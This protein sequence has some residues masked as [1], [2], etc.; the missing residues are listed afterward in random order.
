MTRV[1][2]AVVAAALY[3]STA[4]AAGHIYR[5]ASS[6]YPGSGTFGAGGTATYVPADPTL[7]ISTPFT[8]WCFANGGDQDVWT[9][10]TFPADNTSNTFQPSIDFYGP[11]ASDGGNAV[12]GVTLAVCTAGANCTYVTGLAANS[13]PLL[14]ASTSKTGTV[15][16]TYALQTR[17]T[18]A[19][20]APLDI[21]GGIVCAGSTCQNKT[22]FARVQRLDDAN[23]CVD[24]GSSSTVGTYSPYA[25]CAPNP[26]TCAPTTNYAHTVCIR[27]IDFMYGN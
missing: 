2:G 26:P 25:C 1:L 21:G 13:V 24:D 16:G 10:F 7:G 18:A 5:D 17:S 3:A 23:V 22:V 27:K 15:S 20:I 8:G 19:Q 6:F 4:F 9:S 14:G 11:N 12:F